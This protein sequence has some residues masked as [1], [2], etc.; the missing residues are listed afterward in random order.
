MRYL[1]LGCTGMAGHLIS[2]YLLEQG[3]CV[4]GYSRR[5]T[6][7]VPSFNFSIFDQD[8]LQEAILKADPDVVVNCLGVLNQAAEN[9]KA[10]AV[11]INSYLPHYLASILHG[12]E[13]K[14]VHLST[15]CVFSG[16]KGVYRDKD[17]PDGQTFYDKSKALGEVWDDKNLTF[18][19]SI[20]G[21]DISSD[22]IGLFNWFMAQK[23]EING[24]TKSI[25][26]G[27]TTLTLAKAIEKA[28]EVGLTGLYQLSNNNR[29]SKYEL[30]RLF[31]RHFRD[32][33]FKIK[34]IDGIVQD[35]SLLRSDAQFEFVV[36]SYEVMIK[37]MADWVK[38]HKFLYNHYES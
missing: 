31:N 38:Q 27:I 7:L 1:V 23:D 36:P 8:Q 21:P 30:C 13:K 4:F 2:Q 34:P 15:D 35:K 5:K 11:Y 24:Y 22:G 3:H 12:S 33:H 32:S 14:L 28:V 29:I 17:A 20:I 19:N 10:E 37:E 6:S 26:S 18:R 16:R 25:W 9:N